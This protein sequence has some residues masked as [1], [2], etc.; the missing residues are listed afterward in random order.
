MKQLTHNYLISTLLILFILFIQNINAQNKFDS[1]VFSNEKAEQIVPNATQ[2]RFDETSDFPRYVEFKADVN[3][4]AENFPQWF[5]STFKMAKGNALVLK[6]KGET[7]LGTT[8]WVYRQ[9][10]KRV[11]VFA[12]DFI[13]HSKNGIINTY[14]GTA[15]DIKDLNTVP[16]ISEK[17]A[18]DNI[19]R[20]LNAKEYYWE[21]EYWENEI[22]VRTGEKE[23]TYYPHPELM[24]TKAGNE[25]KKYT[26]A[27]KFDIYASNPSIA[28]QIFIDA[29]S[30]DLLFEI[31]LETNCEAPVNFNSIFNGSRQVRTQKISASEYI[32]NDDCKPANYRV[33]DWNSTTA[34]PNPTDITST[35]N[36]WTTNNQLFGATALWGINQ[37]FNYYLDEFGRDSYD[38]LQ[39]NTEILINA[40]YQR[41]DGTT[42][43]DNATMRSDGSRMTLGR[44]S[45]GDLTN[46]YATLDIIGHEFTHAVTGTSSGLIY[47]SESGALNESFSDIFGEMVESYATGSTD[48]LLGADRDSGHIRSMSAPKERSQPN[49]YGGEFWFDVT[50]CTPSSSN[51]QCGVHRNSGVQ[52][53][54]FFLLSEGGSGT[55]DNGDSYNV[56]GIGQAGASQIAY[57]TLVNMLS[58]N[59]DYM[60]ARTQSIAVAKLL[61]GD[62]SPEALEVA[63]AWHAVGI[64][65]PTIDGVAGPTISCPSSMYF[66]CEEDI[67]DP[68]NLSEFLNAGG[69]YSSTCG[70]GLQFSYEGQSVINYSCPSS[71]T[72]VMTYSITDNSG[73]I[74][75][76]E[77]YI[78][79]NDTHAPQA[80]FIPPDL[81][82]QCDDQMGIDNAL[83]AQAIFIDNCTEQD[84]ITIYHG[85]SILL[86]PSC[87]N[88]Y[89][90]N[91]SWYAVDECLN[92]SA[93]VTQVIQIIDDI[94]PVAVFIP[95]DV[96]LECDDLAGIAAAQ[97]AQATFTDNCTAPDDLILY[98]ASSI[99]PDPNC[100][101]A[102]IIEKSW[103]ADDGCGNMSEI[104]TQTITVYDNTPPEP[105]FVPV[106]ITLQ[107]DNLAGIAA[108][109]AAQATFTD[110]CT[111]PDDLILY[112]ASSISPDPNCPNAYII[113]KSW[114]ADDGCGNMSVTVTQVITV[115]D[116]RPPT[117][118]ACANLDLT[119]ECD[120]TQNKIR[121][122]QW[123]ANNIAALE[124]CAQDNCTD[125]FTGLVSSNYSFNNLVKAC[126][127]T[128]FI[129]A[130]YQV[131]DGC[132]NIAYFY[133]TLKIIDTTPPEMEWDNPLING[134]GDDAY[135]QVECE[136]WSS[137]WEI[138]EFE[139]EDVIATDLCSNIEMTL[140]VE[141]IKGDCNEDGYL[142]RFIYEWVAKDECR[143]TSIK[144]LTVDI[145]DT[146]APIFSGVPE[147]VTL[148]CGDTAYLPGIAMC[149]T[150]VKGMI[151]VYDACECAEIE[152]TIDTTNYLCI[153]SYQIIRKW[154]ATDACGNSSVAQ[155]TITY[156]D[157]TAPTINP[158]HPELTG[159]ANNGTIYL[160]CGTFNPSWIY[161]IDAESMNY[162]DNCSDNHQIS[163]QFDFYDSGFNIACED[164]ELQRFLLA[165][166]ATDDCGNASSY[167]INIVIIDNTAPVIHGVE[168]GIC[169]DIDN[170]LFGVYAQD[171]CEVVQLYYLDKPIYDECL[172]ANIIERTFYATDLCGNVGTTVQFVYPPMTQDNVEF[173]IA[174]GITWNIGDTIRYYCGEEM[175][176]ISSDDI[177]A[178]SACIDVKV[179]YQ[180]TQIADCSTSNGILYEHLWI[181][182]GACGGSVSASLYI[183]LIDHEAPIAIMD[184]EIYFDS[185][186]D[187][188]PAPE[189]EDC[190]AVTYER[191]IDTISIDCASTMVLE[192]IYYATD[193][194]GNT[195]IDTQI[196]NIDVALEFQNVPDDSCTPLGGAEVK[197]FDKCSETY[198]SVTHS[199]SVETCPGGGQ[200]IAHSWTA[201]NSCGE[202]YSVSRYE[203]SD[204]FGALEITAKPNYGITEAWG[205]IQYHSC[206]EGS[207]V[208][209]SNSVE[210]KDYCSSVKIDYWSETLSSE[211]TRGNVVYEERHYWKAT[212]LCG[213]STVV[214]IDIRLTDNEAPILYNIPPD[215]FIFCSDAPAVPANIVA[216]DHCSGEIQ[217][218]FAETRD[219]QEDFTII[220]R[221]WTATDDC[222]NTSDAYQKIT[223]NHE[224]DFGIT[225]T[226]PEN[227]NCNSK[228]VPYY[229]EISGGHQT[230]RYEWTVVEGLCKIVEGKYSDK[231]IVQTGLSNSILKVQAWDGHGCVAE[232]YVEIK[233][234]VKIDMPVALRGNDDLFSFNLYPNPASDQFHISAEV[235]SDILTY[236]LYRIDGTLLNSKDV[237]VQNGYLEMTES[238]H[239]LASGVYIIVIKDSDTKQIARQRLFVH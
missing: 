174:E 232:D 206:E 28:K 118:D 55:N 184:K 43:S 203:Y 54:W 90:I 105:D 200:R 180:L 186:T 11:P 148:N 214:F 152:L 191:T 223:I 51:D 193:L 227:T 135:L 27:Y 25:S 176:D 96:T 109:Q 133:A 151:S 236:E 29:H 75:T 20:S 33:Y 185:C 23:A 100:P 57:Q 167:S 48:W 154:T 78:Y 136:S 230:Y 134:Q 150:E 131:D 2:V 172:K 208:F 81:T 22:E 201:I 66:Q 122:D 61:Y 192:V 74:T 212:D 225:I 127:N 211:C 168:P 207:P 235:S 220:T 41:A 115:I 12:S 10:Y 73:V 164:G 83:A 143:N 7:A 59:S 76:C 165:W 181:A 202:E 49:T 31:P 117:L 161:N 233:C 92:V 69:S 112:V 26:L 166:T 229:S 160:E 126:G 218:Y 19:L 17:Y 158:R 56:S 114:Q 45:S 144:T 205:E 102:Y 52:N 110:N 6:N 99:S 104:V 153:G 5:H 162:E 196:I 85:A 228:R 139:L 80:S 128:G 195:S 147:D 137:D 67:P 121:A 222:G 91:R 111:A 217:P 119:I 149:N 60:D 94:S 224:S 77:H 215:E 234:A 189:Y 188:F 1:V 130:S 190:T 138:P 65:Q 79:V 42:H 204:D 8:R 63:R 226:G 71:F 39:G 24:I 35:D 173:S 197:A 64:G 14:L 182:T 171:N 132:G 40:I 141:D 38:G 18:L 103:Q 216:W 21:S 239:N 107:C 113:E 44:S 30:G 116:T 142:W 34:T 97:A 156:I 84:N 183:E 72:V 46:C 210:V 86:D 177:I 36:T 50:N 9:E 187:D 68:F 237:E 47:Q 155:Q 175:L 89:A 32:L 58:N 221:Y 88:A 37:T 98:V 169:G 13:I 62:C 140:T 146:Q 16:T 53:F 123:N 159:V 120:R 179:N 3:L 101:N 15:Y 82:F 170:P 209:S 4:I 231:V 106:D 213:N 93:T 163:R 95:S 145:I 70:S 198:V 219:E 194:C 124:A 129:K 199:S 87:P 157:D 125:D 238:V 178:E 108:A